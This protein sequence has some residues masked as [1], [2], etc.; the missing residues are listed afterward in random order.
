MKPL[1]RWLA[2]HTNA[3]CN[4]SN[5]IIKQQ[6]NSVSIIIIIGIT[7]ALPFSLLQITTKIKPITSQLQSGANIVAYL[8]T[9]TP[10][11]SIPL[12][13]QLIM[14][15]KSIKYAHY[16][17]PQQGLRSFAKDTGLQE[18]MQQLTPN[19]LPG[20]FQIKARYTQNKS[21]G[22]QKVVKQLS[23]IQNISLVQTNRLSNQ[24]VYFLIHSAKRTIA[25]LAVIFALSII[26]II[27]YSIKVSVHKNRQEIRLLQL[28][29]ATPRFIKRPFIYRSIILGIA[30]GLTAWV[31][32]STLMMW[33][34][35]PLIALGHT[36]SFN[37]NI[38]RFSV[39]QGCFIC[40]ISCL[41]TAT[42][43]LITLRK[44]ARLM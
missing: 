25:A 23:S 3:L 30:G 6:T 38:A 1:K 18:V 12:V 40:L 7:L 20:L 4:A 31:I 36:Y 37:I 41:L 13:K 22:L 19:P 44:H 9:P 28:L 24:R 42:G 15:N 27:S 26:F 16:I 21:A 39:V 34:A 10:K 8:K 35:K 29:G 17:S 33:L 43:S 5:T 2:N 14:Q 11:E 32:S